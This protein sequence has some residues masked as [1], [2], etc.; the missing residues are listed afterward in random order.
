[1]NSIRGLHVLGAANPGRLAHGDVS[2]SIAVSA[3]ANLF[4]TGVFLR[5]DER[6]WHWFIIPTMICGFV[7]FAFVMHLARQRRLFTE[8]S[9]LIAALGYYDTY[10]A[11]MLQVHWGYRILA[12][13]IQ[14][15]DYRPWLGRLALVNLVGISI[16]VLVFSW[17]V[18]GAERLRQRTVWVSER[19]TDRSRLIG[20]GVLFLL[21]SVILQAYVYSTFG[22]VSGYVDKYLN[23]REAWLNKGWLLAIAESAPITA[24]LVAGGLRHRRT[25][26]TPLPLLVLC[27]IAFLVAQILFGGLRGSRANIVV[28]CFIAAGIA[29]QMFRPLSKKLLFLMGVSA[30]AFTYCYGFYKDFGLSGLSV[31]VN[32]EQR[33]VL[34]SRSGHSF[35]AVLIS[36]LSRSDIDSF[37]LQELESGRR[38]DFARGRTYL[39][40]LTLLIPRFIWTERLPTKLKW[41]TELEGG[42]TSSRMYGQLGEAM[43]NFG[44][45]GIPIA[46]ALLGFLIGK[47]AAVSHRLTAPDARWMLAPGLVVT[48]ACMVI[49]DSDNI[50][51]FVFQFLVIPWALIRLSTVRRQVLNR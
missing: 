50:L 27:G 3:C 49:Q 38:I 24:V 47:V 44:Y 22:G 16:F 21:V 46:F 5:L 6:F 42:V 34:L 45:L 20:F 40:A 29:H 28:K 19:V 41:T 7:C 43:L 10:V 32:P 18:D 2:E 23:N 12:L 30:L 35:E 51:Y 17:V 26:Q 15:E 37:V 13:P 36:D 14:P 11:P 8:P 4:I 33:R 1:M 9:F 25:R 31:A 39:G 48:N